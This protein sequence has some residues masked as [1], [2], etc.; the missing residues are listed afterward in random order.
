M[1]CRS[2]P[3]GHFE[4]SL[5]QRYDDPMVRLIRLTRD[6][7]SDRSE[8]MP[9]SF[10]QHSRSETDMYIYLMQKPDYFSPARHHVRTRRH[11]KS[12]GS[13]VRSWLQ[14]SLHRWK[15]RKMIAA[16]EALDDR[17]LCD[18][19]IRRSQIPAVVAGFDDRE[20]NMR[21]V[22]HSSTASRS[23]QDGYALAA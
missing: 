2:A 6:M 16:L 20:L 12:F 8:D 22:E 3:R 15:Q 11:R 7:R 10:S 23:T 13:A 14:S 1:S 9:S 5:K 21:P 4:F 18:I 17:M 19:G